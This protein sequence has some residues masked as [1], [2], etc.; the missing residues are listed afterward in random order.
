MRVS[1]VI[2]ADFV[3]ENSRTLYGTAFILTRSEVAAEE[4]LQDTLARLYPK[5]DRVASSDSPVAYV[6]RALINAFVSGQRRRLREVSVWAVP[7]ERAQG[8]VAEAVTERRAVLRRLAA[9]P[10]RQRA[11]LVM[12][13]LYDRPDGEIAAV[14]DCRVATVRSLISRGL[15]AL[16]AQDDEALDARM[17]DGQGERS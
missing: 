1:S 14:L 9:L 16:R 15:V 17:R 10:P 8:D 12:R 3:H 4:L 5:W 2:F 11:A 13:Y 6:R 7:E